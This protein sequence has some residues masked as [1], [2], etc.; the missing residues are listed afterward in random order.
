MNRTP[1][2]SESL[3]ISRLFATFARCAFAGALTIAAAAPAFA[4]EPPT[5]G[6]AITFALS[7]EPPFV[8]TSINTTLQMGI[9]GSKIMEPLMA[10]GVDLEMRPVLA[11]S[12][13][14]S[15]DGLTY[16]FHLREGVTWHDGEPFTSADVQFT[17]MDVLKKLHPRGRSAFAKV[18][19]VETPDEHT[20]IL[21]L[22][23]PAPPLLVALAS[24]Y[25]APMTPKHVFGG[26]DIPANPAINQPIGTGPFVFKEWEKGNYILLE[27]NPDYW[28]AGKPHLD[29]IVFRI[30]ND[31]SARA[32]GLES[33]EID[34]AG[35]SPVPLTD[36]VR[37]QDD[38]DLTITTDGYAY[39]SPF[40]LMEVN[41]RKPPLDDRRVRQAIAYAVNRD[42]MTKIVWMGYGKPATSPI[43]SPVE[44]FHAAEGTIPA[45][46]YD[47]AKAEALLDEAGYPMKGGKRFS[48]TIDPIPLGTDYVRT[49]EFI[50]QQLGKVG[51]DAS[52]RSQDLPTFFKRVYTDYDFDID[53]LYY[54]A[55]A[56]PTQGVQ[57]L[58]WSKSIQP[59]V[60]YSNPTGYA[61]PEMDRLLEAAQS[62][63]DPEKRKALYLDMQALAMT[64][65][66]VIPLMETRFATIASAKLKNHTITA[67]GVIGGSF[68]DA[69][70]IAD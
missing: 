42:L 54:G 35:L 70:L 14:I 32:A 65:L 45:Y 17:I 48:I 25:E 18:T 4:E 34:I 61:N 33:G 69:Y 19:A 27:K 6:G 31:A 12:W 60:V 68:A 21:K 40:M 38:P 62:E 2:T 22:S 50:K 37:L 66:S 28:D 56:D 57:R 9:V 39:M 13:E 3:V 20:A 23:E 67:D 53:S 16:T 43:P 59:G 46:P 29:R 52:I 63:N 26:T 44:A 30:I 1:K 47:T 11:T 64:D 5:N 10:L 15:P 49:A 7:P 36:M 55:F 58:F 8:L 41:T 24:G 51:I